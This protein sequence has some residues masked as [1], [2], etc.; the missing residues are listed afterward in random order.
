MRLQISRLEPPQS[1]K[2]QSKV[3]R[4]MQSQGIYTFI[5]SFR[6]CI[7]PLQVQ[8]Y[9][10]ALPFHAEAP[11]ANA[12]EGLTQ[13]PFVAARA[14]FEPTTLRTK[15][16]ESTNE[17]TNLPMRHHAMYNIYNIQLYL[18]LP[19]SHNSEVQCRWC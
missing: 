7:V 3:F 16:D 9:S 8:Y 13:G 19:S 12:S 10:E 14:E 17:A 2:H 5:H 4:Q 6:L 1:L 11:Q 15:G 18:I